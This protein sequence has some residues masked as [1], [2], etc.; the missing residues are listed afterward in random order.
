MN[1]DERG[2]AIFVD[3]NVHPGLDERNGS[4]YRLGPVRAVRH[5]RGRLL[6]RRTRADRPRDDR[7]RRC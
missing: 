4:R 6:R 5:L 1:T 2:L 7:R 3:T